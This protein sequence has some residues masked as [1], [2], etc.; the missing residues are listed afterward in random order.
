EQRCLQNHSKKVV[1]K[2]TGEIQTG[3]I[4]QKHRRRSTI[5]YQLQNQSLSSLFRHISAKSR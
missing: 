5:I 1:D 3:N 2:V 4:P